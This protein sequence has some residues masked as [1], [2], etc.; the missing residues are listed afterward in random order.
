M[1]HI[2]ALGT[3]PRAPRVSWGKHP[4]YGMEP[5]P[6]ATRGIL[7]GVHPRPTRRPIKGGGNDPPYSWSVGPRQTQPEK[8]KG[9]II[10]IIINQSEDR[11][12]KRTHRA[13]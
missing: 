4:G 3:S 6:C 5:F 10:I 7:G 1:V 11:G 2:T 13:A 12:R 8:V 9:I